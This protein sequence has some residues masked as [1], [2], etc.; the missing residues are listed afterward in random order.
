MMLHTV[1][2]SVIPGP[3]SGIMIFS[4]LSILPPGFID[5]NF[6]TNR[7]GACPIFRARGIP[8]TL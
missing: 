8:N 5:E 3:D 1:Q 6:H 4:S 2:Y 7:Y